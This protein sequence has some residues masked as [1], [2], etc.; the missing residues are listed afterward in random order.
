MSTMPQG[1]ECYARSPQFTDV[2]V[3]AKLTGVHTTK[4]GVWAR[5]IVEDGEIVYTSIRD[6]YTIHLLPGDP[7]LIEPQEEH[8]VE[9][10]KPGAFHLEFYKLPVLENLEWL[11]TSQDV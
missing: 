9:F 2:N 6:N 8:F 1:A 11:E 3:P 5:L 4:A 7:H 10:A